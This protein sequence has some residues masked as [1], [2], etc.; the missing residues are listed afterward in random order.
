[1]PMLDPT[2]AADRWEQRASQAGAAYADGVQRTD[3]DPTALA[4]AQAQKMLNNVTQAITS[5]RWQRRLAEVGVSGWKSAVAAKVA[6]YA[7]GVT[8]AKSRY[9]VGYGNFKTYMDPY[10]ATLETMPKTSLAD[11]IARATYW[12]QNAAAY[13]KS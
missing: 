8:A 6:N 4:A 2:T 5:G 1:M 9:Q 12:I 3:K 13:K 11:S 7:V 10:L